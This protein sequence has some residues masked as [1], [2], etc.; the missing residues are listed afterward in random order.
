MKKTICLLCFIFL[1]FNSFL[2]AETQEEKGLS[3]ATTV[4]NH[5]K[6]YTSQISY[7]ELTLINAQGSKM[8]RQMK[9][10]QIET[11]SEGEKVLI[12]FL[13]PA[14][15]KGTKLLTWSYKTKDDSQWLFLPALNRV[16]RILS[17]SKTGSFMGSEFSYEDVGSDEVEKY[18]YLFLKDD[19]LA[20]R[21][22]W[23]Y[24]RYPVDK[25]SGYSKQV[26]WMDQDYYRPLKIEYY[27]RKGEL[28][29]ISEFSDFNSFTMKHMNKT[30]WFFNSIAV[31]NVQ[32]KKSST[33]IWSD[34]EFEVALSPTL[35]LKDNLSN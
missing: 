12:E 13:K 26:I 22:V 2:F 7:S 9:T 18:T 23:I 30:M 6:G 34:R 20:D 11:K 1:S 4:Y 10:S 8:S 32:T 5:N 24:E 28:L 21:N 35:F 25:N 33:L 27:D 15:V 16:K 19:T 31:N 29:K 17:T 3:I 14:N